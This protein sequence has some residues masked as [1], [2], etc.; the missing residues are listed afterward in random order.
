MLAAEVFTFDIV[1]SRLG[2][3][4][5]NVC[6]CFGLF[7]V[8]TKGRFHQLLY[9]YSRA[10]HVS[11]RCIKQRVAVSSCFSPL[12]FSSY[13]G[14]V[15]VAERIQSVVQALHLQSCYERTVQRLSTHGLQQLLEVIRCTVVVTSISAASRGCLR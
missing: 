1:P 12:G 14:I 10:V 6:Y 7:T 3:K 9:S 4:H 15:T 8:V 13:N 5:S 2:F 11:A